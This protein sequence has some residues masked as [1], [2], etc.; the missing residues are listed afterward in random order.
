MSQASNASRRRLRRLQDVER[1]QRAYKRWTI[2]PFSSGRQF[3]TLVKQQEILLKRRHHHRWLLVIIYN[4]LCFERSAKPW[5][6]NDVLN[7][8]GVGMTTTLKVVEEEAGK[9]GVHTLTGG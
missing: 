1:V 9:V 3:R 6:D 4:V 7:D 5:L 2:A 8:L